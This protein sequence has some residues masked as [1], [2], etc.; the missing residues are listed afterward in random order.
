[1]LFSGQRPTCPQGKTQGLFVLK[2]PGKTRVMASSVCWGCR[3]N[4]HMCVY[5][6]VYVCVCVSVWVG[7]QVHVWEG[8]RGCVGR[9]KGEKET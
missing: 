2:P 1:M 8:E 6:C 9:E 7:V 4:L 5:V 3:L